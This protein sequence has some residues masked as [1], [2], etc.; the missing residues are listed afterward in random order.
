MTYFWQK[1]L[2]VTP[3]YLHHT[4]TEQGLFL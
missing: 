3:D 1:S 4:S 2:L